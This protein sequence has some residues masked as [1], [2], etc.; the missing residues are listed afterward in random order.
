[1]FSKQ[2]S[3]QLNI[4]CNVLSF[5][6]LSSFPYPAVKLIISED[7]VRIYTYLIKSYILLLILDKL[8][9]LG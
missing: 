7:W 2:R 5:R 8:F 6:V 1:V 3:N 4:S 9:P